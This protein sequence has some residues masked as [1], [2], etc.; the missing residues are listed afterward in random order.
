MILLKIWNIKVENSVTQL[1]NKN[2]NVKTGTFIELRTG[3]VNVS[4]IGRY[5]SQE[6]RDGF[7]V[8]YK[9]HKILEK[10]KETIIKNY[11]ER[12]GLTISIGVQISFD[13]FPNGWD[14]RYCLRFVEKDY[15]DNIIF[16]GD[17][18]YFGGNGWPYK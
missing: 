11:A 14:K 13:V 6:E 2:E 8:Y 18:G 1:K 9:E 17:K 7:V 5:C 4:P 15:D 16:F 10:F 3:L 12:M